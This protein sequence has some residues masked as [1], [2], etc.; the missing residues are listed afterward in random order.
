LLAFGSTATGWHSLS[1][2]K[3]SIIEE[4]DFHIIDVLQSDLVKGLNILRFVPLPEKFL[5]LHI[6]KGEK[7]L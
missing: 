6:R 7:D 5:L 4:Y 2:L 3:Y 1:V